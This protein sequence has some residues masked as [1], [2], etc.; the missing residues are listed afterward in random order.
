MGAPISSGASPMVVRFKC[1]CEKE[2]RRFSLLESDVT[3]ERLT[4]EISR[5]FPAV[6]RLKF[7][8]EDGDLIT[9][10][11]TSEV[12]EFIEDHKTTINVVAVVKEMPKKTE[13][14][15]PLSD[16]S[17][18]FQRLPPLFNGE[19]TEEASMDDQFR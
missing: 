7:K 10:T 14:R 9:C 6:M 13:E 8:D 18:H 15:P 2:F 3:I 19:G 5:F 12:R 16:D 1:R 17:T 4:E 11:R